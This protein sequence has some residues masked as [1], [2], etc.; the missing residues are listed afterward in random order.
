MSDRRQEPRYPKLMS[1]QLYDE[2]RVP[3][4][5]EPRLVDVSSNGLCF[6][7]TVAPAVG[8][9]LN[10]RLHIPKSGSVSGTG[11]VRWTYPA[12]SGM[13]YLSGV[14]FE[15][16]G[17]ADKKLLR[18]YLQPHVRKRPREETD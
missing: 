13:A 8:A 14:Q 3:L 6:E 15:S 16:F 5:G 18:E 10:F 12:P 11:K 7:S 9:V 17:W 4:A 2:R 1:V